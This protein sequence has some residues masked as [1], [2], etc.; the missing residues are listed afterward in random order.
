MF[1][2]SVIG[3]IAALFI[4][5]TTLI[6]ISE[7]NISETL[8]GDITPDIFNKTVV[9][10][11]NVV[12]GVSTVEFIGSSFMHHFEGVTHEIEGFTKGSFN[13]GEDVKCEIS[14][15]I[16]TI[17]GIALGAKK[18][19]LTNNI[20]IN[21]EADNYPN[22]VFKVQRVEPGEIDSKVGRANFLV[23]GDLTIH[24]V[25]RTIM[26]PVNLE[27]K[28]GLL[29]FTGKYYGLNMRDY[30]VEPKPLMAFIKVGDTVDVKFDIYE[31]IQKDSTSE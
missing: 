15:P 28:D 19:G 24:N 29:R 7:P 18:E 17:D 31:A 23:K 14:I 12:K 20:H 25:T 27:I 8:K 6:A 9:M 22:I 1:S 21:L 5:L 3:I 16:K 2:R 4:S 10:E 26:F 11:F 13:D 30:G